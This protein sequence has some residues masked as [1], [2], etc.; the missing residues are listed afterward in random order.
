MPLLGIGAIQRTLYADRIF[1]LVLTFFEEIQRHTAPLFV[2]IGYGF[3]A[4]D[5]LYFFNLIF[6]AT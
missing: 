4:H 6:R 5:G 1:S 2:V 3:R